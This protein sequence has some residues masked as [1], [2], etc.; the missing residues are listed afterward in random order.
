MIETPQQTL[1]RKLLEPRSQEPHFRPEEA[2]A[3]DV[4]QTVTSKH[5]CGPKNEQALELTGKV[6]LVTSTAALQAVLIFLIALR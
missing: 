3:S 4:G 2:A 5:A 6:P 1:D